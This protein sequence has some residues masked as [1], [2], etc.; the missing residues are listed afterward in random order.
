MRKR[1]YIFIVATQNMGV[2][3]FSLEKIFEQDNFSE[4]AQALRNAV[5][6]INILK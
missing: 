2:S 3:D 5:Q 6:L 4:D 1:L